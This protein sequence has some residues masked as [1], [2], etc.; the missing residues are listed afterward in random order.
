MNS[1]EKYVKFQFAFSMLV[2]GTILFFKRKIG[3]PASIIAMGRGFLG[4]L[5]LLAVIAVK[6][7]KMSLDA[8]KN[9][10]VNLFLS[11]TFIGFNW[12]FLF[13]ASEFT[14]DAVA[15][16]CYYMAPVIVIVLSPLFLKEKL[17]TYKVL[18]VFIALFGMFFVSGVIEE[19]IPSFSEIK[20][21]LFGLGAAVLYACVMILNKKIT[22]ISPYDKTIYQLGIAGFI[23]L[24]YTIITENYSVLTFDANNIF[25]LM[26]V[27]VV[28]TGI[29]YYLYF[30]A[31]SR[32]NAQTAS[33]YSYIDPAFAILL[34]LLFQEEDF[35]I[36][37]VMG[38][39]LI[40]GSTFFC[41][42]YPNYIKKRD[43]R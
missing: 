39:V 31:L 28:H 9:N 23:L 40:F 27:G 2:F 8:F 32:L 38:M 22:D 18:C 10:G 36:Y 16:L 19:G 43:N 25:W 7:Q 21:I 17:S 37:K 1:S 24:P 35:G 41:E 20:G 15:I 29:T 11:G 34:S 13:K 4:M 3:L 14:S 26:V 5:F 30:G 6:R 42:L 33:L 12:I